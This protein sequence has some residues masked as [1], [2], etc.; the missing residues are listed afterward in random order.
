VGVLGIVVG[1]GVQRSGL[2][3]NWVPFF[4][5]GSRLGTLGVVGWGVL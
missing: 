5:S 1:S 3:I 2:G 4:G